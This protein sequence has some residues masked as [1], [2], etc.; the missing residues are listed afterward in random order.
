M[1]DH[2]TLH[3]PALLFPSLQGQTCELSVHDKRA[4]KWKSIN[5]TQT[6]QKYEHT[7]LS[8]TLHILLF[9]LNE[10]KKKLKN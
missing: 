10:I 8:N 1:F 2:C 6:N 9:Q 4:G 7:L 3:L 5:T